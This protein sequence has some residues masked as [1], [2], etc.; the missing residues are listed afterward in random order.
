MSDTLKRLLVLGCIVGGLL[1]R[2]SHSFDARLAGD[3]AL[4]FGFVFLLYV[5]WVPKPGSSRPVQNTK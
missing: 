3:V 5:M 2:F 4:L 1:L